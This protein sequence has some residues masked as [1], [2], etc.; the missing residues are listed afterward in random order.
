MTTPNEAWESNSFYDGLDG[1][2]DADTGLV[3]VAKGTKPTDS[4]T[5]IVWL[6]RVWHRLARGLAVWNRGRVVDEGGLNVGAYPCDYRLGG[7]DK[8]YAGGS[9]VALTDNDTNY[10][11]LDSSNVL[12][13]NTTGFPADK[14]TFLPLAVVTTSGG[15]ITDVDDRRSLV[16]LEVPTLTSPDDVTLEI[17]GGT[18]QIKDGGVTDAKLASSYAML[19]GRSGGQ[20][21][22]GG[23]G[24]GED[25]VIESTAHA[26]KGVA[27][28]ASGSDLDV[29]GNSLISSSASAILVGNV[30]SAPRI[31]N[32]TAAQRN[33]LT[34]AAGMLV[35]NTDAS[36]LEVYTSAW[37]AVGGVGA[38]IFSTIACPAGT[39]PVADS[40]TDTL[41]L[42][43]SN[44]VSV[45]GDQSTDTVTLGLTFGTSPNTVCQGNDSR[46][47]IWSQAGGKVQLGT[48]GDLVGIGADPGSYKLL[49]DGAVKFNQHLDL[50]EISA[51]A[52]PATDTGRIYC[53][54]D[55]TV[56]HLYFK[57]QSG[58]VTDL[59]AQ[60][61]H[62]LLSAVHSDTATAAVQRG[63]LIVGD[64]T[65]EWSRL[66]KGSANDV[67]AM[68][69]GGNDP[70]WGTTTGTG[71]VVRASGASVTSPQ[72][73]TSIRPATSGGATLGEDDY[74]WDYLTFDYRSVAPSPSANVGAVWIEDDGK[75]NTYLKAKKSGGSSVTVA[76]L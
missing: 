48:S 15:D 67:L 43:A 7:S 64:S 21:L 11:Y 63:D 32:L 55:G 1:Q 56:T 68:G 49:V 9:G 52:S 30:T 66:A 5:L 69:A 16:A 46:L 41:T 4:P 2:T 45:T 50:P 53:A 44:G 3:Y 74:G 51:P 58:T 61:S 31:A 10:V 35:Y 33:S 62:N 29:Q 17:S 59:L 22:Q 8:S 36:Q 70:T 6:R 28:I 13:T 60:G 76:T 57:D 42:A 14:S 71:N 65:P 54:V 23:T 18:L 37:G 27:Q 19:A 24:D 26:N 40:S 20:T 73:S 25:L 12:T 75:G 72:V 39:N 38:N 34:P 47:S